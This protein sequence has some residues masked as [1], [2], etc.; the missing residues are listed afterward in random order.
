MMEWLRVGVVQSTLDFRSAWAGS[1]T[2]SAVEEMKAENEIDRAINAFAAES[3]R[4]HLVLVPELAAP[5]GMMNKLQMHADRLEAIIIAGM[6]YRL[7]ASGA[8]FSAANESILF[9]PKRW[10][11]T[12]TRSPN[13]KRVIGKT[14]PSDA[15]ARNLGKLGCKFEADPS[16]WLFDGAEIGSFA[17]AICYDFLDLER[18]AMY[19]GRIHHFF[20]LAYNRDVQ[21][22]YHVA[23]AFARMAVCNVVVCNTGHFGGSVAVS[24]YREPFRRTIYRSEGLGLFSCQIFELPVA[25][26]DSHQKAV[27][28][29]EKSEFKGR[30]PGY[31]DHLKL[32]DKDAPK[33]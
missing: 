12:R 4:P 11:G 24:P 13:T 27:T 5:R 26:L 17:V 19:R 6:D 30:P 8:S 2:M 1:P 29:D 23:E 16:V 25:S 20:V 22:F 10:L 14:Y 15:E 32:I 3:S 28:T 9:I 21:S 33:F 18:L 31:K 7:S